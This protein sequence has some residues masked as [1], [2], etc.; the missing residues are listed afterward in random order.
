MNLVSII[1]P[2]YNITF[3]REAFNSAYNQ[4]YKNKEIIIIYDNNKKKDFEKINKIIN[5]KKNIKLNN[6]KKNFGVAT[7]RNIGIKYAKGNFLA[8]LDS[9]D[10]W[11]KNK[12]KIQIDFM[13][14]YKSNFTH[15]S[16]NIIDDKN[17]IVGNQIAKKMLSYKDL[18]KSCDIGLSTVVLKKKI[19]LNYNFPKLKT[20]EDYAL[21]LKLIK[22]NKIIGINKK[23]CSWRRSSQSLSSSILRK[24]FDAFKVYYDRENLNFFISIFRVIILSCNYF[25]K[26]IR[27]KIYF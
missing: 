3:F 2:V 13:K 18:L 16:Y 5:K 21:W 4:N 9:D 7:A 26:R 27:Q 11:H 23:L 19:I 6:N 8:F 14:R 10:C 1:I 12:L 17:K 22:K 15:T 20:K 24:I 25:F